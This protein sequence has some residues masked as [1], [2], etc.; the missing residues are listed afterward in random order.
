MKIGQKWSKGW[1]Q[2]A[3]LDGTPVSY[4]A[5]INSA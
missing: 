5:S 3:N 2:Q 4:P 1:T